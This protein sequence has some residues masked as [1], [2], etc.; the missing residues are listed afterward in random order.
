MSRR[1][2]GVILGLDP[3]ISLSIAPT[4]GPGAGAPPP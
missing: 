1:V 3:R 2:V 4:K